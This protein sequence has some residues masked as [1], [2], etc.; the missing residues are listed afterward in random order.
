MTE[1]TLLL[2][3]IHPTFVKLGRVTSQAFR[4]TP[5]DEHKLSVYDGDLI[6]AA[7]AWAHYRGRKLESAGVM[8]VS[9]RECTNEEL[10]VRSSPE[11]F[12]EHA[13]IDFTGLN[14]NQC[15]KK[16]KRLKSV[17]EARGWLYQA[18]RV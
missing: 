8:A 12:P 1:S 7:D 18:D 11:H 10:K 5:K 3:Q 15:E 2:R 17:A 9:V 14:A 4:P 16:G 6:G 13:E